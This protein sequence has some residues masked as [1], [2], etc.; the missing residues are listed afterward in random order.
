MAKI[1]LLLKIAIPSSRL[2]RLRKSHWFVSCPAFSWK[3]IWSTFTRFSSIV[4]VAGCNLQQTSSTEV[5]WRKFSNVLH[6]DSLSWSR[7]RC[8]VSSP[9]LAFKGDLTRRVVW[10]TRWSISEPHSVRLHKEYQTTQRTGLNRISL[11]PIHLYNL[12]DVLFLYPQFLISP[13][14]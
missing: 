10:S 9:S 6:E 12:R 2:Q 11:S 14:S 1:S 13:T 7:Q 4:V 3:L 5:W 8:E